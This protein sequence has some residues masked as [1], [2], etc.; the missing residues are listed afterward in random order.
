MGRQV[1]VYVREQ[2]LAL[3]ERAERYAR[4]RRLAMSALVLTALER[5]LAEGHPNG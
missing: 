5:Y 2:D 1:S 3:W 4:E